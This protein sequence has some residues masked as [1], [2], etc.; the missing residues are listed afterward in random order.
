[1]DGTNNKRLLGRTEPLQGP[2]TGGKILAQDI[3]EKRLDSEQNAEDTDQDVDMDSQSSSEPED[4]S[5][6]EEAEPNNF[7]KMNLLQLQD[8]EGEEPNPPADKIVEDVF[9][10]RTTVDDRDSKMDAM[11]RW[12]KTQAETNTM[13]RRLFKKLRLVMEPL[14]ATKLR[15][16][17]HAVKCTNMIRV[18]GFIAS[19]YRKDKIWMRRTKPAKRNYRVLLS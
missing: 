8:R 12:S 1:M 10:N 11:A 13:P 2:G 5:E 17:Y 18:I 4:L 9:A 7:A 6:E 3:K 16:D 14:L 15:G 19:G